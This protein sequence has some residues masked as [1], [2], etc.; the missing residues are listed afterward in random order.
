MN[1]NHSQRFARFYFDWTLFIGLLFLC[2][3][4]LV[5]LYSASN[6]DKHVM[7]G[8]ILRFGGAFVLMFILAQIP[9]YQFKRFAPWIY[10]LGI[11]LLIVVLGAG[12]ISK[13]AQRWLSVGLFRFQP[14]EIMKLAVPLMLSWYLSEHPLPPRAKVLG[15]ALV[16]MI[17]PAILTA[18][19]PDLGTALLIMA[20]GTGVILLSGIRWRT[21]F[22][23][24]LIICSIAPLIW[25]HM[26]DYQRERVLTFL[27]PESDPLGS[28][29]HIIQSKIAIGSGGVFGKGYLNGTQAHLKFL[30]EHATDFIFAVVGEE[31]GLIGGLILIGL[32]VVLIARGFHISFHAQDTFSRLLSGSISLTFFFSMFINIG[33]VTGILPVV[34]LPLPLVSYGGTSMVT[35]I[36][37]FGI[38]MSIHTHRKL[39]GA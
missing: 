33:M 9:P 7:T 19:Q 34:G 35:L 18:K 3:A 39:L 37:G 4:G 16:L 13:G 15:I 20:S 32:Y 28:G 2:A 6:Q 10:G 24:L 22:L 38:L 25:H 17:V 8:Q 36:A 11:L 30:P 23:F 27:H 1:I 31:T 26:H 12:A 5:I 21:V 29:Y 14:S